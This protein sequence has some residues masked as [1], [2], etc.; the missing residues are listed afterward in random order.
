VYLPVTFIILF[1]ANV[2]DPSI[3]SLKSPFHFGILE[4]INPNQLFGLGATIRICFDIYVRFSKLGRLSYLHMAYLL[5]F[6]ISTVSSF[7]GFQ[8]NNARMLQSLMFFFNISVCLWFY[9]SFLNLNRRDTGNLIRLLKGVGVVS[10]IL[11]VLNFP[12]THISFLF[13]ALSVMTIY[14]I[15]KSAKW[16]WY[17]LIPPTIFIV[18][19]AVL[20]LSVT[21]IAII[22][23]S[24]MI[25][26]LSLKKTK[27]NYGII[28][29]IIITIIS[30]Q[31]LIFSLP[32]ME[33]QTI[34]TPTP[35]VSHVHYDDI[36]GL[37]DRVLFKFSLDRTPLWLG[38]INGIK[39][40]FL[41]APSG[42]T[43]IP[44]NF[45]TFAIPERQI[46]WVAGAHQLQL[47]LMINYGL[48][49]AVLYWSI[50]ISFMRKLFVAIFSKNHTIKYLS[51]S[52]LAYFIPSS[53]IANFII[54]EHALAAW[55]LMG[56]TIALHERHI[57]FNKK[58]EDK[59]RHG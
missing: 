56:V 27:F 57:Y 45:G 11:Y 16:Y 58:M 18:Q 26:V 50:W 59:Y 42:S 36:E 10:L 33:L 49:G 13:I 1:I 22:A 20:Y 21:T 14:V 9:E 32:L 37:W 2:F 38:A 17:L 12:N 30:I 51:V 41:F 54:Q 6:V 4:L 8:N 29:L 31:I 55:M 53:F 44:A 47:E 52:L 25:G 23:F 40:S 35:N 3:L 24:I 15:V 48:I 46:E 5:L 43:F 39:E 28:N 19:K 34:L 7:Y